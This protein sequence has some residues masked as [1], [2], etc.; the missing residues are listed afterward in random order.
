MAIS[1]VSVQRSGICWGM[2]FCDEHGHYRDQE[3]IIC[4][5]YRLSRQCVLHEARDQK[6]LHSDQ[7]CGRSCQM[8]VVEQNKFGR[9]FN[10]F[11]IK[12]QEKFLFPNKVRFT[13]ISNL[14]DCFSANIV[15]DSDLWKVGKCAHMRPWNINCCIELVLICCSSKQ[16]VD[17]RVIF[18][19]VGRN[20]GE[21]LS[22]Q[23]LGKHYSMKHGATEFFV[24]LH[25][26]NMPHLLLKQ[27]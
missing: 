11:Q 21:D 20:I 4:Y 26:T 12:T 16:F 2:L 23:G 5:F 10:R 1:W 15:K 17:M 13:H 6:W 24:G 14:T 9:R 18:P 27:P 7:G 22:E 25:F 19:G 8:V 3:R